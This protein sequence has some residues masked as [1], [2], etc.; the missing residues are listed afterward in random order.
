MCVLLFEQLAGIA[1]SRTPAERLHSHTGPLCSGACIHSKSLSDDRN[2][3][4][5]QAAVSSSEAPRLQ[6]SV[7][8]SVQSCHSN[9]TYGAMLDL[10]A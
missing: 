7:L 8:P 1:A 6:E 3:P 9:L 2:M 4:G 10:M 5:R